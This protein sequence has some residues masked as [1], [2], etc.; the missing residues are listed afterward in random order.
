MIT[1]ETFL[2]RSEIAERC[3]ISPQTLANWLVAGRGPKPTRFGTAVRFS[4]SEYARWAADPAAYEAQ[5]RASARA[6]R[7]AR[8][9]KAGRA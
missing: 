3:R 7:N 6:A 4:E 9:Q 8:R 2:T 1:A 5:T